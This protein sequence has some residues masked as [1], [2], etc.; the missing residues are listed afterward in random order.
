MKYFLVEFLYV[1]D[2]SSHSANIPDSVGHKCLVDSDIDLSEIS[3]GLLRE[4][5]EIRRR[6]EEYDCEDLRVT[7][8]EDDELEDVN[9]SIKE[10]DKFTV[11]R[12]DL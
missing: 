9:K 4:V 7:E 11:L 8:L 2:K 1:S 10:Q 6:L 5:G 3:V 12:K